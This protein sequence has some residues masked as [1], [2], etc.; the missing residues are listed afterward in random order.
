M[1]ATRLRPR[2]LRD[3]E[4]RSRAAGRRDSSSRRSASSRARSATTSSRCSASARER[5]GL[6][7]HQA[8]GEI[9]P[10]RSREDSRSWRSRTPTT[11]SSSWSPARSRSRSRRAPSKARVSRRTRRLQ[12]LPDS[13]RL[14]LGAEVRRPARRLQARATS[15]SSG[16]PTSRCSSGTRPK[17]AGT[18]RIIPS[19]R[20]TRTTWTSWRRDPGAVRAL[21]YDVVLNGTELGSGSIRIHR[22][23][24]QSEDLQGARHVAKRSS[25]RASASS[26]KRCS[27]AR[28]RTAASR[29]DS[30]AS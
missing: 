28:L 16:S 30:I 26:S 20:R 7:R 13:L 21:A 12:R 24:I 19:P 15:A 11:C 8:A 5:Q 29:W 22:Q 14:A 18:R 4:H 3:A 23:D 17:S 6:R 10:R 1:C 2:T 27:T 9:I 25:R